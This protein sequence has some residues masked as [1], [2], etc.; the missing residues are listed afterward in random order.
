MIEKYY[1]V[2]TNLRLAFLKEEEAEKFAETVREFVLDSYAITGNNKIFGGS[3]VEMEVSQESNMLPS[4][5][6]MILDPEK[7][8]MFWKSIYGEDEE[9]IKPFRITRKL[10]DFLMNGNPELCQKLMNNNFVFTDA[11]WEFPDLDK[12]LRVEVLLWILRN[13]GWVD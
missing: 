9:T 10:H 6:F 5:P 8:K 12:E 1:L 2:K 11:G 3:V 7:V 13:P 4:S